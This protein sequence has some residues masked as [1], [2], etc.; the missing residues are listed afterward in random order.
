M[1]H[2]CHNRAPFAQRAIPVADGFY[3]DGHT[4]TP[5]L[6]PLP[7]RMSKDCEYGKSA[8]ARS[9]QGCDGCQWRKDGSA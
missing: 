7:F 6:V 9:D 5:R 4:R 2:G 1:K 3:T 8:E